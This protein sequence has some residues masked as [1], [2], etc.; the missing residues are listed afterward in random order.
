MNWVKTSV[1]RKMKASDMPN[2]I[3]IVFERRRPQC[4]VV[5]LSFLSYML[6]HLAAYKLMEARII[7]NKERALADGV[8]WKL[9]FM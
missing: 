7:V 8:Y 5:W 1:M 9:D 6:F 4:P 2:V 3:A